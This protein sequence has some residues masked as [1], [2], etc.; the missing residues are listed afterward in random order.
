MAED[1]VITMTIDLP[2]DPE[3]VFATLTTPRDLEAWAWAGLGRDATAETDPRPGG[4]FSIAI[5]PDDPAGWPRPRW[6]MRGIYVEVDS[7]RRLVHTLHWDAPM[8][9][10]EGGADV[11]DEVVT[12]DLA[13][14][15]D[16][17][18]TVLRYRHDGIPSAEAA[19]VHRGGIEATY[20]LLTRHLRAQ[21]AS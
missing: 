10:N 13:P 12:I 3:R 4:R 7:P 14:G 18:T 16:P 11:V 1:H 8:V 2:A 9:Y 21:D 6:A 17:G 19:A 5:T 20:A 15:D